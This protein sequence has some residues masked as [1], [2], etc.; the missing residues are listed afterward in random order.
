MNDAKAILRRK[1]R[2]FYFASLFLGAQTA[3][4]CARLYRFC[5]Y[6]DYIADDPTLPPEQAYDRLET[7]QGDIAQRQ[8]SDPIV[9]DFLALASEHG[10]NLHAAHELI[11]GAKADLD[12]CLIEDLRQLRRYAYRVA[13]TVGVMIAPLIGAR[14]PQ[15]LPYAVDLGIGMQLTNIARDVK[16]DAQMGRRYLPAALGCDLA[17]QQILAAT[18]GQ[19]AQIAE[20]VLALLDLAEPYYAHA[21]LG[22]G[23][24][25]ARNRP[26][27]LVAARVYREIGQRIREHEGNVL[28]RRHVCSLE[29]KAITATKALIDYA[30]HQ[31]FRRRSHEHNDALHH[32]L[33]GLP[34]VAG[35][36]QAMLEAGRRHHAANC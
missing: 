23:Y 11:E 15:A 17:P 31:H 1:G 18:P 9:C 4:A 34:G 21:E 35:H 28:D 26:G 20:A 25:E 8:S 5:R 24:I 29:R 12:G 2:S 22:F 6:V 14:E 30:R 32:G 33:E 27:F 36:H 19:R 10:V 7:I 3:A 16:E 13:G